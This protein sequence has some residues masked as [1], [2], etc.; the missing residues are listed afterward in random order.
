MRGP[1]AGCGGSD[2]ELP[3]YHNVEQVKAAVEKQ[4][5]VIKATQAEV[6]IALAQMRA[7]RTMCPHEYTTRYSC[8]RDAG[9][10]CDICGD[11]R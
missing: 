1:K 11:W 2:M 4:E 5:G 3:E 6:D 10:K 9:N 8:G 7:I